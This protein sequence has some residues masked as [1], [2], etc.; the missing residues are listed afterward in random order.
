MSL[1]RNCGGSV[2]VE[3]SFRSWYYILLPFPGF[4]GGFIITLWLLVLYLFSSVNTNFL[5]IFSFDGGV[6]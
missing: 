3:A 5:S 2:G 4:V 1:Y 6:A